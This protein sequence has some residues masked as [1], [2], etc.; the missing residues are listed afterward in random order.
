MEAL[1]EDSNE[2][3]IWKK[4]KNVRDSFDLIDN[5]PPV[6]NPNKANARHYFLAVVEQSHELFVLSCLAAGRAL[7]STFAREPSYVSSMAL[8]WFK[9]QLPPPRLR[10][11]TQFFFAGKGKNLFRQ[12]K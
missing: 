9:E 6:N 4:C 12:D 3:D 10:S 8:S 2:D 5:E 11:L 1:R 7:F